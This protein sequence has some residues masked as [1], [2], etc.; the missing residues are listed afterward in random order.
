VTSSV[1]RVYRYSTNS[2]H[3]YHTFYILFTIE[4]GQKTNVM[5]WTGVVCT[6]EITQKYLYTQLCVHCQN[7]QRS[8][9]CSLVPR[10][11]TITPFP[12]RTRSGQMFGLQTTVIARVQFTRER[13]LYD[14]VEVPNRWTHFVWESRTRWQKRTFACTPVPNHS[15]TSERHP[16]HWRPVCS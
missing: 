12:L 5:R 4:L 11:R 2:S 9:R 3:G 16:I 7:V 10:R 15:D 14:V 1:R 13:A 6:I 8:L